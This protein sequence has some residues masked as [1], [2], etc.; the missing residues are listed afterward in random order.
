MTKQLPKI[1]PYKP[2]DAQFDWLATWLAARKADPLLQELAES[3][4]EMDVEPTT[5][6]INPEIRRPYEPQIAAGQVRMLA[7]TGQDSTRPVYIAVLKDW[8]D[9]EW[10]VAPFSA[11]H[12]PALPGELLYPENAALDLRVL[13]LWN[14]RTVEAPTLSRSWI[15]Q[16]LTEAQQKSAWSVFR[17]VATGAAIQAELLD[18]TGPR[19]LRPDDPRIAY[20]REEMTLLD[21]LMQQ[22]IAEEGGHLIPFPERCRNLDIGQVFEAY[23]RKAAAA[24]K[25]GNRITPCLILSEPAAPAQAVKEGESPFADAE[26]RDFDPLIP[27]SNDAIYCEWHINPGYTQL[28]E[29]PV[30]TLYDRRSGKPIARASVSVR[31]DDIIISLTKHALTGDDQPVRDPSDLRIV[32]ES[33]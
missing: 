5:K 10:L 16:T 28:P 31:P 14:A 21:S 20:Q 29:E 4:A 18:R 23:E 6:T 19:V 33:E 25:S 9:D 26:C 32:I 22:P 7:P 12:V 8:D 13:C 15:E 24:S 3:D 30:A 17:H 27:G 2:T 11:Y 1:S